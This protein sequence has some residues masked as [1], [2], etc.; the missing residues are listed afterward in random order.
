MQ[1][2]PALTEQVPSDSNRSECNEIAFS[3]PW[4]AMK[5]TLEVP[6]GEDSGSG[7]CILT[8]PSEAYLSPTPLWL[9]SQLAQGFLWESVEQS[10]VGASSSSWATL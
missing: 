5:S 7:R 2:Y 10:R 9:Q 6:L 3:E 4:K 1:P 8:S